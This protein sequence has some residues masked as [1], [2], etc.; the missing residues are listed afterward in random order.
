[1]LKFKKLVLEDKQI[2]DSY[3]KPSKF[4][5]SE[6]SFIT[7]YIWRKALDI[8][9]CICEGALV[10]KKASLEF[11]EFFM[12]PIGYTDST[13]PIILNTLMTYKDSHNMEYLFRNIEAPFIEILKTLPDNNFIFGVEENNFDY[14]YESEKLINLP[15]RKLSSK[16]N[17]FTR[18]INGYNYRVEEISL[19]NTQKCMEASRNWC[20]ENSC[21]G[22]LSYEMDSILDMLHNRATLKFIGMVVYVDDKVSA[23]SIGEIVSEE[24]AII[25]IEKAFSNV[26]GL[27]AFINRTFAERYLK[28]IKYINREDDMGLEGLRKAKES[29]YPYKLEYKHTVKL[30]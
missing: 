9:Y 14:I 22:L 16:R 18:F 17:H 5:T 23:F 21:V 4:L 6:Y 26:H 29:Y 10:L 7:L 11:G 28:H 19:E 8:E 3:I 1:M 2:I 27:Y 15:G 25:H 12:Q 13:L 30:G 20:I 24:M